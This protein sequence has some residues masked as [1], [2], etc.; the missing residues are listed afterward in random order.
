MA[1]TSSAL[2]ESG[3]ISLW[4]PKAVRFQIKMSWV[5]ACRDVFKADGRVGM[6]SF[7][8]LIRSRAFWMLAQR[9][10][11]QSRSAKQVEDKDLRKVKTDLA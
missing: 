1:H 9:E 7:R 4:H 6:C 5:A 2:I 10:K 3:V 8:F 11:G